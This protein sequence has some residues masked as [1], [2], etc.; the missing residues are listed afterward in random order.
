MKNTINIKIAKIVFIFYYVFLS[1][2]CFCLPQHVLIIPISWNDDSWVQTTKG[3]NLFFNSRVIV[4]LK[5]QFSNH[6]R[7]KYKSKPCIWR[8]QNLF[9]ASAKKGNSHF[10]INE[11]HINE[12][13]YIFTNKISNSHCYYNSLNALL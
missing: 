7:W 13:N 11:I 9:L 1:L 4:S 5:S 8:Q 6:T 12:G 3:Y 2:I 10:C